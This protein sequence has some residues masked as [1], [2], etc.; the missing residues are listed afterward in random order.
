M[1]KRKK[2][3]NITA[4]DLHGKTHA[5]AKFFLRGELYSALDKGM[6]PI[7]VITGNSKEM[8]Q[9]A[10]KEIT[11]LGFN[12]YYSGTDFGTVICVENRTEEQYWL[13]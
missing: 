13:G 10:I 8:N 7:K 3:K 5:D 6:F 12:F 11:D 9:I 2:K 1:K 4:I